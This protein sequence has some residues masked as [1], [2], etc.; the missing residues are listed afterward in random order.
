MYVCMYAC[1]YV[2]M[3]S[4]KGEY[5]KVSK[6][7]HETSCPGNKQYKHFGGLIYDEQLPI[8]VISFP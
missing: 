5:S 8:S 3:L 7:R 2:C 1:M 4:R 6:N